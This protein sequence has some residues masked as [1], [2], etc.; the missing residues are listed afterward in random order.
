VE[1]TFGTR[2]AAVDQQKSEGLSKER[3]ATCVMCRQDEACVD[4]PG[5]LRR[6]TGGQYFEWGIRT[7]GL[8]SVVHVKYRDVY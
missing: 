6:S 3:R 7:H 4:A 1:D 2:I 5:Y 8:A